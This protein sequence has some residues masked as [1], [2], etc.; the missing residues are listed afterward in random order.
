V[1]VLRYLVQH[2]GLQQLLVAKA[3]TFTK[4]GKAYLGT[5]Y[6]MI[7]LIIKATVGQSM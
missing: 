7:G 4:I 2:I 3:Y 1:I 6:E 5:D